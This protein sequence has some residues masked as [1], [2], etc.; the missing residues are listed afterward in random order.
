MKKILIP[1]DFSPVADNALQY[2]I[3]IGAEFKS[4]L[5]LY[6][7]Y[8]INK[9][10]YD[11]N[12][13]EDEQ[14][15]KKRLERKMG[16]TELKFS[17]KIKH[18]ELSIKTFVERGDIPALFK[19]IAKKQGVNLIVMGSK[20]ASGLNKV[21]FGSVAATALEMAKVPVLVIPPEL[22]F[23]PIKQIVIAIDG[24]KISK[25]ILFPLQELAIKFKAKVIILN[26]NSETKK[27]TEQVS[28]ISFEGIETSFREVPMNNN[29][30]ETINEFIEKGDYDLLCM[31]RRE[32]SF[33]QSI[34]QRSITKAQVFS[35]QV[36]LLVLPEE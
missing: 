2:A 31:I 17:E 30:N 21:I 12:L 22:S 18:K 23:R 32:K 34:F 14:P 8:Y 9:V 24:K 7:T 19:I 33:F 15:F 26:V 5:Y 3:E 1:T 36:P 6:H 29:I 25:H 28:N 4:M 27:E 35:N 11:L 20:G 13:S 10:D 16:L